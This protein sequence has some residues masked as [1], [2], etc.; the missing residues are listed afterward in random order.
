[1]VSVTVVE[2]VVSEV[3]A[4]RVK[5]GITLAAFAGNVTP[6]NIKRGSSRFIGTH[7]VQLFSDQQLWFLHHLL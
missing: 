7:S 3:T 5:F 6:I 1:M 2:V 4:P